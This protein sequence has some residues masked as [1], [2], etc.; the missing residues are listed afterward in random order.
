[1]LK[2]EK[3]FASAG[4]KKSSNFYILMLELCQAKLVGVDHPSSNLDSHTEMHHPVASI[5]TLSKC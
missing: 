3:G 2:N 5:V 4:F 1:M